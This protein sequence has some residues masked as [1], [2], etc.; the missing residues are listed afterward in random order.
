MRDRESTF[1]SALQAYLKA[2][3][4]AK[5]TE[6]QIDDI[7]LWQDGYAGVASGLTHYPGCLVIIDGRTIVD[8]FTARYDVLVYVGITGGDP[9]SLEATGRVWQDILEDAIRS[10]WSLGGSCLQVLNGAQLRPGWTNNVYTAGIK[11]TCE[12]DVGGFVYGNDEE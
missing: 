7:V 12:V 11:F 9:A 5:A 8:A 3:F 1:V 2:F 4:T 10:D 6:Q